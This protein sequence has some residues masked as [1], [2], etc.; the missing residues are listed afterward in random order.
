MTEYFILDEQLLPHSIGDDFVG[1]VCWH[2][3]ASRLCRV[4]EEVFYGG[5]RLLTWFYGRNDVLWETL[6]M[7][8]EGAIVMRWYYD[9]FQEALLGHLKRSG[10]VAFEER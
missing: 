8:P 4:G 10:V 7:T 2:G 3:E 6:L 5:S 1:W 9:T